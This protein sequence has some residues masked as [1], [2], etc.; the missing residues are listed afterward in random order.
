MLSP[1]AACSLLSYSPEASLS[2]INNSLID[3]TSI[4]EN[5]K[6]TV[7]PFRKVLPGEI[8]ILNILRKFYIGEF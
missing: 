7:G 5:V 3:S 4:S 1:Q 2:A 8:S 6:N